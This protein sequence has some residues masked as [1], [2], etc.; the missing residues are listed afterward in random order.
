MSASQSRTF[1]SESVCVY[2]RRAYR[3]MLLAVGLF[4]LGDFAHT[5]LILLATQR[6]T[7]SI[8]RD[9]SGRDRGRVSTSCTIY[10]RLFC[11]DRRMAGDGFPST[12]FSLWAI[13]WLPRCRFALFCCHRALARWR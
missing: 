11:V 6:L 13:S 9:Q 5:M 7:P 1:L 4:G 10:S 2:C 3:K 8:G 12:V